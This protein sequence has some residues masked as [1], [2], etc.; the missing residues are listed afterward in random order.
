MVE[1]LATVLNQVSQYE[2]TQQ[3]ERVLVLNIFKSSTL[4]SK[5]T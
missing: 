4:A 3:T 1:A 5:Y 2:P